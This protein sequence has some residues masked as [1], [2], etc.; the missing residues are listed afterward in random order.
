[1]HASR[2]LA[3]GAVRSSG[4]TTRAVIQSFVSENNIALVARFLVPAD[5]A[6][7]QGVGKRLQERARVLGLSY[8]AVATRL[9]MSQQRYANYVRDTTE[10]DFR[11]LMRIC[12][13]LLTTPDHVLGVGTEVDRPDEASVLWQRIQA[14]VA[15]MDLER[16]RLTA[17]VVGVLSTSFEAPTRG[18]EADPD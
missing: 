15:V 18:F 14:A 9:D 1:M 4:R 11:T 5:K 10:P 2:L 12:D 17:G 13:V 8:S 16:L 3:A 7:M 6:G